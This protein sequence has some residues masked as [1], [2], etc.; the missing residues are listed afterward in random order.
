M[1]QGPRPDVAGEGAGS[2]H[3]TAVVEPGATVG[4]GSRIWHHAQVREGARIGMNC[5]LGKNAFIDTGVV[6]GDGCKIQNNACVY[7]GVVL[8]EEVFVGPGA[9]LTNDRYPRASSPDWEPVPTLVGRGASIG[10][11]AT[12][13]CG[14]VIG[15][16]AMVAAGAVVTADIAPHELVA[17][18]PAR[19]T[20]WVC[21]CGGVL[22]RGPD[23]CPERA[24][25]SCGRTFQG[26]AP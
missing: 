5:T 23:P 9:V 14:L 6:V 1:S 18:S 11:N 22:Q 21:R 15:P 20:G 13:V 19:R 17:G 3:P 7:A 4:A 24:C 16:W 26:S 12:V 2:V 25:P 10:A 8:E